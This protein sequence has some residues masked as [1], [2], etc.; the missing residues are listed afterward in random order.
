[1]ST[2]KWN[3]HF[4]LDDVQVTDKTFHKSFWNSCSCVQLNRHEFCCAVLPAIG[5]LS[6]SVSART[7]GPFSLKKKTK[8]KYKLFLC[9]LLYHC[10]VLLSY[11]YHKYIIIY[12]METCVQ[13]HQFIISGKQNYVWRL[14][15]QSFGNPHIFKKGL[16]FA[17][18]IF[19]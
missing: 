1:M 9:Q 17:I 18:P 13:F 15:P 5:I 16:Y 4:Q 6:V 14:A 3:S 8:L 10:P 19:Y 2:K 7:I 11:F 12:L